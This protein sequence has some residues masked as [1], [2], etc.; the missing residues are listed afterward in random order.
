MGD[1]LIYPTWYNP[2]S[3]GFKL[4]LPTH[5]PPVETQRAAR[6]RFLADSTVFQPMPKEELEGL[7]Y[8]LALTLTRAEYHEARFGQV[9]AHLEERRVGLQTAFT[10]DLQAKY[11]VFEAAAALGAARQLLDELAHLIARR[12]GVSSAKKLKNQWSANELFDAD[13]SVETDL[14]IAE[15]NALRKHLKAYKTLNLYRNVL[16]HR[17]WR[18]LFGK[19]VPRGF[20][21]KTE[22]TDPS[23]DV[24]LVPDR[25]SIEGFKKQHEWTF[26]DGDRLEDVL[27][28]SLDGVR[29][30]VDDVCDVWGVPEPKPGT[31]PDLCNLML[32]L[33]APAPLSYSVRD[34][35]VL[36][37]FT[38]E[39][40]AKQFAAYPT[41]RHLRL[42]RLPLV[43]SAPPERVMAFAFSA[44]LLRRLVAIQKRH[45]VEIAIDAVT[46][47][48]E[49]LQYEAASRGLLTD[50][51][52]GEPPMIRQ[53]V[54]DAGAL[55]CWSAV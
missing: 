4:P 24:L 12:H 48:G 34:A 41:R 35:I 13:L 14:A 26:K 47:P 49:G 54:V 20:Q 18:D 45:Y 44:E 11:A 53:D 50:L 51:I 10:W 3:L 37:F 52:T 22:R 15:V 28:G 32:P 9:V 21:E 40:A 25:K 27:V 39:S 1:P 43:M 55:F 33:P 17:G 36:P 31:H 19:Y 30:M 8:S 7:C 6:L 23:R 16:I 38:S 42:A 46:P 5:L 2:V 29:A